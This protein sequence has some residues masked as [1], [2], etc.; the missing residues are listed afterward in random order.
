MIRTAPI[1]AIA[2]AAMVAG[3]NQ[4]N[5]TIVAGGP[6]NRD[7]AAE[8]LQANGP[9]ELPPSIASTKTYRCADNQIVQVNWMSDGKSATIRT[10]SGGTVHV[11]A[12]EPGKDMIAEGGFALS[13]APGTASVKIATGG[14]AQT[15]KA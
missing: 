11:V 6:D 14:A 8:Q 9:V 1:F 15:C 2:A 10:D 4:D 3:C 12:P 5:H 7:E 13:G